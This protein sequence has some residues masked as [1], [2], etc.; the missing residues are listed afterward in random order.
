MSMSVTQ[1]TLINKDLRTRLDNAK[2]ARQISEDAFE[3][4]IKGLTAELRSKD[5]QIRMLQE[6]IASRETAYSRLEL[7]KNDIRKEL[8]KRAGE[9]EQLQDTIAGLV[10]RI[11]RNSSN[12][13]KLPSTDGFKKVIHNSRTASQKK[14][15][16]QL[17]HKGHGLV[18]SDELKQ[19]ID[20]G[21]IP[22]QIIEH[23][24][25][26]TSF[27]RRYELDIKTTIIIKEHRFYPGE[28]IPSK[29][30]NPVNYGAGLKSTCIFLSTVGLV[31]AERVSEFIHAS[32]GGLITPSKAT[33]LAFQKEAA[34]HLDPEI[35]AIREE[36]LTA[37]VI[38]TDET[39]PQIH[40][41]TYW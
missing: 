21:V 14:P 2:I 9:C 36:L 8:E 26:D 25:K 17:G 37:P 32:T 3:E 35:E 39:P 18:L 10:A 41:K 27:L 11:N 22:V 1:L 15:G 33:I 13:S 6:Y 23:G 20:S 19:L 30:N 5:E 16:G 38:N 4:K 34:E 40:T 12:S 31:A 29:L 28:A 7:E 24:N